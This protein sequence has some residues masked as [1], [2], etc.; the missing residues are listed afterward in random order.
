MGRFAAGLG[1]H[2]SAAGHPAV[3]FNIEAV[4]S[5]SAGDDVYISGGIYRTARHIRRHAVSV[6]SAC[7]CGYLPS[8]IDH[9]AV[10]AVY[11]V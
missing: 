1:F 9:A 5:R 11:A 6:I 4:P 7:L 3:F 10:D 2:V 8:G